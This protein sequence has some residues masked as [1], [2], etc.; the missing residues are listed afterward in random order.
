MRSAK[1]MQNEGTFE[2]LFRD[3]MTWKGGSSV[4]RDMTL[5]AAALGGKFIDHSKTFNNLTINCRIM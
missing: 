3:Q 4:P 2:T 1:C 5:G